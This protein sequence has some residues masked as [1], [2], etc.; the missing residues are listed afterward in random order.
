[1][2]TFSPPFRY[3][4]LLGSIDICG[5]AQSFK[6]SLTTSLK[7]EAIKPKEYLFISFYRM[8][9]SLSQQY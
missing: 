9:I 5:L 1:M 3:T 8:A 4:N 7:K 2:S 6:R